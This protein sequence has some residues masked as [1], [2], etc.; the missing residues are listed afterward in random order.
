VSLF[1]PDASGTP[2]GPVIAAW[3]S[4]VPAS[5]SPEYRRLHEEL[6]QA[7]ADLTRQLEQA[8]R[9]SRRM[10]RHF[11]SDPG[12]WGLK[13]FVFPAALIFMLVAGAIRF[14][15]ALAAAEGHGTAGYF[16]AE[17]DNCSKDGCYWT[18][19][20]VS[21]DGRVTLR[22]VGF[23]GPHGTLYPGA[24]LTALDTGDTARVYARHG[25]RDWTADLAYVAF[26][27]IGLG[28]WA[29][30]VPYRTTRS[31]VRRNVLGDWQSIPSL[32]AH[33]WEGSDY[34]DVEQH[35]AGQ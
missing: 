22:N 25:S 1:H 24:R 27:G 12:M 3:G 7:Q 17:S 34:R 31:W 32:P 30:R 6:E 18:G 11:R 23:A 16:V 13:W 5:E 19:N 9:S 14:G 29:W 26:G 15:P 28:L 20:F 8:R 33:F 2:L 21:P 4:N 35:P 10:P